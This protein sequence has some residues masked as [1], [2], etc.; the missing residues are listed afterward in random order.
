M[1]I[2]YQNCIVNL[3][4]SILKY[5]GAD[6]KHNTLQVWKAAIITCFRESK[7][8]EYTKGDDYL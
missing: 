1:L 2:D 3:A 4:C 7:R 6:Y 5:Y 8:N